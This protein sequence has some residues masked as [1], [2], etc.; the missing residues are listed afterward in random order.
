M[1]VWKRQ[2]G[3]HC[4]P[5]HAVLRP[6]YC[7]IN[8]EELT[9]KFSPPVVNLWSCDGECRDIVNLPSVGRKYRPGLGVSWIIRNLKNESQTSKGSTNCGVNIGALHDELSYLNIQ[10]FPKMTPRITADHTMEVLCT[11]SPCITGGESADHVGALKHKDVSNLCLE[12]PDSI[13]L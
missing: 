4:Y 1:V 13:N 12:A 7:L 5:P 6:T 9:G 8:V 10:L 11:T 2:I 3:L